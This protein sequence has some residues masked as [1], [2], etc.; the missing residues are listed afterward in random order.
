M[1]T[2]TAYAHRVH[3]S[4]FSMVELMVALAIGSML[5]LVVAQLFANTRSTNRSQEEAA[6]MQENTR[7]A[8]ATIGRT[9]RLAGYKSNPN[10][11]TTTIFP[12]ATAPAL[13]GSDVASPGSDTLIVR[14]QGSGTAAGAADNTVLDCLGTAV[15]PDYTGTNT[16]SYNRFSISAGA[17][18]NNALFCQTNSADPTAGTELVSGIDAMQVLFG[19]DTSSP[20]DSVPDR[21]IAPGTAGINMDNVVTVRVYLLIS[22]VQSVRLDNSSATYTLAGQD[23]TYTDLKLRR[24]ATTTIALRNRVP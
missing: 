1:A 13:T 9:V 15:A 18:G 22:S 5:T 14:F 24:V 20:T 10:A 11:T 23:Y 12:V 16:F 6:R 3:Q 2:Q 8:L 4:G 7:F 17:N 19:E 21:F